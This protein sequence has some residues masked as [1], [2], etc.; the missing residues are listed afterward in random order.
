MISFGGSSDAA[1]A[2][3]AAEADVYCLWGEPLADTAEQIARV[4]AEAEAIGRPTAAHPGRVSPDP[5]PDRGEGVG[6]R[7]PH[8][9]I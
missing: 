6:T 1:Y 7:A 3:G 2:V 4:E 5:R 9:P 8:R